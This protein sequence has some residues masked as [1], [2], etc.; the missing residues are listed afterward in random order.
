[1]MPHVIRKSQNLNNTFWSYNTIFWS[2][3]TLF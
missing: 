3:N 1:V 2:L